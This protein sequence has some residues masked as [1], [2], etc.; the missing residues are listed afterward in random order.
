MVFDVL[1]IAVKNYTWQKETE[2]SN[3]PTS[4]DALS[5]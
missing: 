1:L 4:P 5:G 3:I 2:A